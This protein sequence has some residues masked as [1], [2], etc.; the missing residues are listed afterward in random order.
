M[1]RV[2]LKMCVFIFVIAAVSGC[3]KV[4]TKDAKKKPTETSEIHNEYFPVYRKLSNESFAKRRF[5]FSDLRKKKQRCL[6]IE[7]EKAKGE[8]VWHIFFSEWSMILMIDDGRYHMPEGMLRYV[9]FFGQA[10]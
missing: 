5:Y 3:G 4:E 9:L 1:K 6:S 8:N 2:C 7:K 10:R